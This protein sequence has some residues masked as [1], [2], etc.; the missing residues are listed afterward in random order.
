MAETKQIIQEVKKANR[1]AT[2]VNTILWIVIALL[3]GAAGWVAHY[4]VTQKKQVE[5]LLIKE[6][7]LADK[8]Q[9]T[10]DRLEEQTEALQLSEENLLAEKSKLEQIQVSYDSIRQALLQEQSHDDLWELTLQ[11]NTVQGY[12]DYIKIKGVN[13]NAVQMLDDKLTRTGY[14]Q[15]EESNGNMLFKRFLGQDFGL[16]LWTPKSARSVR[17]GVIGKNKISE[18]TGDVILEGQPIRVVEDSIYT[19]KARWAKIKY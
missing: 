2:L 12:A 4:A 14:I 16:N 17:T 10:N 8:L 19:G 15:I 11:K 5:V 6:K 9:I 1:K 7:D 13:E 18:R 3:V